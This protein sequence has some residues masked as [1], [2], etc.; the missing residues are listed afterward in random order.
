MKHVI[1]LFLLYI[2]S[3]CCA[4]YYAIDP[5]YLNSERVKSG[6]LLSP[7]DGNG[8]NCSSR[9][10]TN[11]GYSYGNTQH[12]KFGQYYFGYSEK[13]MLSGGA[14]WLYSNEGTNGFSLDFQGGFFKKKTYFTTFTGIEY[15]RFNRQGNS[16]TISPYIG[17]SYPMKYLNVIQL[18]FGYQIGLHQKSYAGSYAAINLKFPIASFI[19]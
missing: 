4:P 15:N 1:P 18:N 3:S 2:L 7:C 16:Q 8:D 19:R 9:P 11:V 13:F 17:F 5:L 10:W 12:W 14:N 6:C